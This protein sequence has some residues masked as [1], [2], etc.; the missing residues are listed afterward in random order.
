MVFP[1]QFNTHYVIHIRKTGDTRMPPERVGGQAEEVT[2][3]QGPW[4]LL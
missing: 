1:L 4:F 3:V 2:K